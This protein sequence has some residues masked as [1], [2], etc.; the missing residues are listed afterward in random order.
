MA[1]TISMYLFGTCVAF[2][3]IAGD[4]VKLECE[5]WLASTLPTWL[6]TRTAAVLMPAVSIMLPLSL[7]R[8]MGALA[9]A[10]SLAVAV[11]ALTCA[12]IAL[13]SMQDTAAAAH[14]A[15]HPVGGLGMLAAVPIMVFAYQCHVQAV[16]IFREL[17]AEPWLW[18]LPPPRP[19]Q[20]RQSVASQSD[21]PD[22]RTLLPVERENSAGGS[23]SQALSQHDDAS[24]PRPASRAA[25]AIAAP[26]QED[27]SGASSSLEVPAPESDDSVYSSRKVAGMAQVFAAASLECSVLYLVT[28]TAGYRM[29]GESAQPNILNNFPPSDNLMGLMRG[30]VGFA[31]TLHYPINLHAARSAVYD[32]FCEFSGLPLV[33]EPP[34]LHTAAT[35][36]LLWAGTAVTACFVSDLGTV[37]QIIGGV[38]GSVVIF[39]LPGAL[40]IVDILPHWHGQHDCQRTQSST[41]RQRS[42]GAADSSI[43]ITDLIVASE[44]VA[45]GPETERTLW[46]R[47][48]LSEARSESNRDTGARPNT[49]LLR[50]PLSPKL[51]LESCMR[52]VVGAALMTVG[53]AVMLIALVTVMLS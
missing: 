25:A 3:I 20:T 42:A 19:Q 14:S 50:W 52:M 46:G 43:Q 4:T 39:V 10:S 49:A 51:S 33:A 47:A 45:G 6:L 48:G 17:K 11:M 18:P 41:R 28:G 9:P 36:V 21:D 15:R 1:A 35:A 16:P 44:R 38:A 31:V 32:L 8:T 27:A 37:F 24:P 34:Y 26:R 23:R 12:A 22:T 2:M 29:F 13:R 30:C 7:Q 40:L 53:F 5:R